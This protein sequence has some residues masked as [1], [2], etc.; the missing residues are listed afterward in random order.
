MKVIELDCRARAGRQEGEDDIDGQ[1]G[2]PSLQ[3]QPPSN[4]TPT[5]RNRSE[6]IWRVDLERLLVHLSF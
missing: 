5:R 3:Q 4:W 1:L 2:Q 6:V